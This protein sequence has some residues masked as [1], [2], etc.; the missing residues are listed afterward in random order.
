MEAGKRLPPTRHRIIK[1]NKKR[2]STSSSIQFG[3]PRT[4]LKLVL[5]NLAWL[6]EFDEL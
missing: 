1:S 6:L 2:L 3:M 4:S 5:I